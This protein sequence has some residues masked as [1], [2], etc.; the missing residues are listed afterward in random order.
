MII[1][2][3]ISSFF[4]WTTFSTSSSSFFHDWNRMNHYWN[5]RASSCGSSCGAIS[6]PT[7]KKYYRCLSCCSNCC[8][9]SYSST[10]ISCVSSSYPTFLYLYLV[11]SKTQTVNL[12]NISSISVCHRVQ[13]TTRW[14]KQ[15]RQHFISQ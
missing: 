7:L 12:Q 5:L 9:S 1:G 15:N 13:Q 6:R 8:Y 4:S 11:V 10:R 2:T 3:W 14:L